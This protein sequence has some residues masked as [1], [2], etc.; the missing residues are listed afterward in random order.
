MLTCC[1]H[2]D[3]H[4]GS[5]ESQ[6]EAT[7][8]HF[9]HHRNDDYSKDAYIRFLKIVDAIDKAD[10]FEY[11]HY[12][13]VGHTSQALQD[14]CKGKS[15]REV[16]LWLFSCNPGD[17]NE[18]CVINDLGIEPSVPVQIMFKKL[19]SP[20]QSILAFDAW[21][22]WAFYSIC[23]WPP[24]MFY[25]TASQPDEKSMFM[26]PMTPKFAEEQ[27]ARV[28]AA[29]EKLAGILPN[30]QPPGDRKLY[31]LWPKSGVAAKGM[32]RTRSMSD[33]IGSKRMRTDDPK[34]IDVSQKCEAD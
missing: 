16:A 30:L 24:I 13:P 23:D 26:V 5:I 33:D 34:A 21:M 12:C 19:G 8:T 32:K 28:K 31:D 10:G 18:H 14:F 15:R 20:L 17:R 4:E 1:T 9:E 29:F 11:Y 27:T 6:L 2:P 22:A 3:V 7:I 25:G